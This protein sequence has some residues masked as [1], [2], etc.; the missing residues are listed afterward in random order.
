MMRIL[1]LIFPRFWTSLLPP[2]HPI[3]GFQDPFSSITHLGGATVFLLLTILLLRRGK[4]DLA[5]MLSLGVFS[6]SAVLLLAMSGTYH[7][8]SLKEPARLVLQRLDHGAIFILIAGTFTPVYCILFQGKERWLPLLVIWGAA[9]TGIV[10]KTVYFDDIS[11][12]LG[13]SFYLGLGWV[14]T[15]TGATIWYRYGGYL[16]MPLFLG[17]VSYTLGAI[18]DYQ[19]WPVL[20][21]GVIGAHELFHI[22][23]LMGLGFHWQFVWRFASGQLAPRKQLR[24]VKNR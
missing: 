20:L 4:G 15:I 13:M 3:P 11:E 12:L 2:I 1:L 16:M 5:R 21:P 18:I 8:M 10:L 9:I 24:A 14:G 22:F 17:A 7:L 23:V 6:F 19:R